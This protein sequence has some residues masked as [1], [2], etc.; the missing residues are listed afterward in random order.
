VLV[1]PFASKQPRAGLAWLKAS[2]TAQMQIDG[3]FCI[4]IHWSIMFFNFR[5]ERQKLKNG[6][7]ATDNSV[8]NLL[9]NDTSKSF[10][11]I[12]DDQFCM[13]RSSDIC[14]GIFELHKVKLDFK[15]LQLVIP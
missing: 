5:N 1:P 6:N 4:S 10:E 13:K 12:G 8:Y 2:Q 15:L 14:T 7:L 9:E 11:S 3:C